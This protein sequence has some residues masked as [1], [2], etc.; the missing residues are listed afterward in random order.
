MFYNKTFKKAYYHEDC[1]RSWGY[2]SKVVFPEGT[3]CWVG[4]PAC[5][6]SRAGLVLVP[7]PLQQLHPVLLSLERTP[8]VRGDTWEEG[9]S[10]HLRL[11]C[12][13]T[14]LQRHLKDT[15]QLELLFRTVL[16]Q[17]TFPSGH[18]RYRQ[19]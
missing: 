18:T 14:T 12:P 16:Y 2:E 5:H 9:S 13:T 1:K 10:S 8:P 15:P 19:K 3:E 4:G 7:Q 11:S 6:V 17:S